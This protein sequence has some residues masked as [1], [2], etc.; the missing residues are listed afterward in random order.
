MSGRSRTPPVGTSEGAFTTSP[1]DGS[2]AAAGIT[3]TAFAGSAA[4]A[5]SG[6]LTDEPL[7]GGTGSDAAGASV[8]CVFTGC[9]GSMRAGGSARYPFLARTRSPSRFTRT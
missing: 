3:G 4:A 6:A 1:A 8:S 9:G 5:R 2:A 7:A